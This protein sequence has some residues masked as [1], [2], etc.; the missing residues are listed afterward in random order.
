MK[1]AANTDSQTEQVTENLGLGPAKGHRARRWLG[2]GALLLLIAAGIAWFMLRP[3]DQSAARYE[4]A[5]VERSDLTVTVSATGTLQPTNQVEVGSELSGTIQTVLVDDNS[6]VKKGDILAR[7]DVS[8]LE[9]QIANS[10]AAVN[11]AKASVKQGEATLA[12]ASANLARLKEVYKLSGGKVPSKTELETAEATLARA[13]ANLASA[14]A[15]VEQAQAT[16]RTNETNLYKASLRSP[17][18][19]VVLSRDAEPGQTVAASLQVT[20]LFTLAEDLTRMELEVKVDEADVGEVKEGQHAVFTVD[21]Y[22]NRKYPADITRVSFGSETTDNVVTYPTILQVN[23][24]DLSLRPGM[25][26]TAEITTIELHDVLLVPNAA[27]RYT[28]KRTD[29]TQKKSSLVSSLMPRPPSQPKTAKPAK[30]SNGKRTI[31]VLQNGQPTAIQVKTGATNGRVT[32][33]VEGDLQPDMEVI[34]K[35]MTTAK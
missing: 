32:E 26:A 19:G 15:S 22:P 10:R 31:W 28:P 21:A 34:T 7:L 13:K 18:N 24:D 20:T 12:E 17:I 29:E 6:V 30:N 23:N 27:L 25:T 8:K 16:L 11:V 14:Q 3:S 1:A 5:K 4:T 35:A 9:D 2:R 33:I